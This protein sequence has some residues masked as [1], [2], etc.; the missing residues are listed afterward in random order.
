MTVRALALESGVTTLEDHRLLVGALLG[1]VDTAWT[2]D[3][4]PGLL[5]GGGDPGALTGSGMTATVGAFAAVVPGASSPTQGPYLVVSTDAEEVEL[6]D[7]DAVGDRVD[8]LGVVVHDDV[9]DATGAVVA[10]VRVVDPATD[11]TVLPLHDVTVPQGAS[12][13]TGGVPWTSAVADRRTYTSTHGGVIAVPDM[14]ARNRL[15]AVRG[16]TLVHVAATD[17]LYMRLPSG[18]TPVAG[19]PLY[20]ALGGIF[21]PQ[22]GP[23]VQAQ[24]TSG[25]T[26][27][28]D[29]VELCRTANGLVY[30]RG[31]FTCARPIN[32]TD[33]GQVPAGF[34]PVR[35]A[36]WSTAATQSGGYNSAR[37][38]V[39]ADGTIRGYALYDPSWVSADNASWWTS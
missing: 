6:L 5:G 7:G 13:G 12:V 15:A 33:L 10:E 23:W 27:G 39:R 38:E 30:M 19:Q 4:R 1:G 16:G 14:A 11:A 29:P 17:G 37:V 32:D 21:Q 24:L 26:H 22:P 18:W 20:D 2:L 35:L 28:S 36:R 3:R 34:E 9:Y 8:V 31:T 25:I